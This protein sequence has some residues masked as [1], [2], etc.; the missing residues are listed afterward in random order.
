MVTEKNLVKKLH[1]QAR[2]AHQGR[3]TTDRQGRKGRGESTTD[4]EGRHA[5]EGRPLLRFADDAEAANISIN[6]K[7]QGRKE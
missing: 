7:D 1:R 4:R 5:R 3:Y 2:G 6:N